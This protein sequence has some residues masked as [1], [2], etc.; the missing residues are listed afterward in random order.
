MTPL[1][2]IVTTDI[3]GITR[4][5]AV[6][7]SVYEEGLARGVG[8][9]PANLSLTPFDIIA[10]GNPWGSRGD[11]RLIPDRGARFHSA[12]TGSATPLDFV[13]AD[14]TELDGAPWSCCVRS[15][16]KA[17]IAA[18]EARAGLSLVAAFEQEFLLEAPGLQAAPSFSLQAL[19]RADPFGPR[20][21]AALAQTGITAETIL[22]EYGRDQLELTCAPTDALRAADHAVA[23]REIARECARNLGWR[24]CFAPKPVAD[25]VGNGV[26]V[27]FSLHDAHGPKTY[28]PNRPGGL[29]A[30]AGAF[31]AGIIRHLP[32]LV[33]FTAPS[34]TSYLRLQPHSWS[35]S[36]TWL[37][38]RDREASLRICPIVA[39]GN[40][41]PA[42]QFNIEYRA[43]DA[44]ASPYL[45]LTA[46]IRAGLAGLEA[47]LSDPPI[48]DDD[49]STM[50]E[51]ARTAKGL[52]RLPQSL[53][54]ALDALTADATARGW[55]APAFI[56]TY[57]G[58]KRKEIALAGDGDPAALCAR[59]R[60]IY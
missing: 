12:A 15:Q 27:H 33:A 57:V 26:H 45:V 47:G 50:D 14:V 7:V 60:A 49:P 55:F 17:A 32:A 11:L 36:Y 38:E 19:R 35:A 21:I 42:R 9:V 51:A 34:V 46:L 18:L 59:Y 54:A 44:A 20:L 22:A 6:P 2:T 37:G 43:A 25:A 8:W 30:K 10:D 58:M 41:D 40:K 52:H 31:C 56:A 4:G 16:L 28:D 13:M 3:S 5:R 48:V 24:A 23:I 53:G 1:V 29:S 39:I